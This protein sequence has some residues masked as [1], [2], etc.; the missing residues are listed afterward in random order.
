MFNN[1]TEK[2]IIINRDQLDLFTTVL[3]S[4]V[5][6]GG[7]RMLIRMDVTALKTPSA[8]DIVVIEFPRIR[9]DFYK[10]LLTKLNKYGVKVA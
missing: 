9:D 5:E 4:A 3:D 10:V 1:R 2:R 8:E 6:N 7:R